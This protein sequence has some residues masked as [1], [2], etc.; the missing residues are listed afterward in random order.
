MPSK[1]NKVTEYLL[2]TAGSTLLAVGIY[3]F[4]FLNHF[5]TGGVSGL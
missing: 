1:L 4:E 2:L 5:T 3:F